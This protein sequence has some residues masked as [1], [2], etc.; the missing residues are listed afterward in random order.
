MPSFSAIFTTLLAISASALA[1]TTPTK[2]NSSSNPIYNPNS[3]SIVPVGKPYKITWGPTE[4]GTVS[5]VLL[6]GPSENILPLYAIAEK[7]KNTGS[8]TWTPKTDLEDD[9]THYGLQLIIDSNGQFQYS[10]QF[11]I[12]NPGYKP[13]SS[14]AQP[15]TTSYK[16]VSSTIKSYSTSVVTLTTSHYNTTTYH[17]QT[18]VTVPT[19]SYYSTNIAPSETKETKSIPTYSTTNAPSPS[20]TGAASNVQVATGLLIGVAGVIA[21]LF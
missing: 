7:I 13:K 3:G 10:T 20:Q 12:S 16:T 6:R 5:I 1:Y 8:Y 2:F 21:L 9:K 17:N 18:Y 19:P 15:T 4:S 11:G 14:S